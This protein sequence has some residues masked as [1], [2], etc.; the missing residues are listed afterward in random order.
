M[1]IQ[2]KL[3]GTWFPDRVF[4]L[5]FRKEEKLKIHQGQITRLLDWINEEGGT[6]LYPPRTVSSTY[7]D[8]DDWHMFR[9]SEEG[10]VPR[11]K[12]RIRSYTREPHTLENSNLE[13]KTSSIEGRFKTAT[14]IFDLHK[15]VS[16]GYL[17]KDYGI[18]KP[19]VRITY[20]R[21]YYKILGIRLTI[22]RNIEYAK[23]H[24]SR[25]SAHRVIDS[26]IAVELKADD[27]VSLAY[28]NDKFP[29]DRIRFSKYSRAINA[30]FHND[31]KTY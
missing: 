6:R 31:A 5:S 11:K 25:T 2:T 9:D 10:C 24:A 14:K 13:I 23:V 8:T 7:F 27:H 28:L 4:Q 15:I 3:S 26:E 19:R 17:D 18:C 29:F 12:I 22:D 21:E 1:S 30:I 16:I 20:Q